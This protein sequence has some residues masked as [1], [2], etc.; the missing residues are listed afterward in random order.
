MQTN[1]ANLFRYSFAVLTGFLSITQLPGK[2]TAMTFR[3]EVVVNQPFGALTATVHA[4]GEIISGDATGLIEAIRSIDTQE[5]SAIFVIFDSLG[6]NLYEGIA[7]GEAL[8]AYPKSVVGRIEGDCASA[9][10]FAFI[11]AHYRVVA[12]GGRFGVHQ[13]SFSDDSTL[14]VS[15]GQVVSADVA[16]FLTDQGVDISFLRRM[17]SM[18]PEG[19]D[20]VPIEELQ[21]MGIINGIVKQQS[22]EIDIV[23]DLPV[24]SVSQTN[25]FGEYSLMLT[26]RDGILSGTATLQDTERPITGLLALGLDGQDHLVPSQQ[27]KVEQRSSGRTSFSFQLPGSVGDLASNSRRI[28]MFVYDPSQTYWYGFEVEITD[29]SQ[30]AVLRDCSKGQK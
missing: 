5:I 16:K 15:A 8:K 19:I 11:G 1:L 2:A 7:M 9:C 18:P 22:V 10:T 27:W 20:W 21:D 14:G 26:C 12:D 4:D 3:S 30:Y 28:G 29:N 23:A 25:V 24:L 6:G 17:A 13:F